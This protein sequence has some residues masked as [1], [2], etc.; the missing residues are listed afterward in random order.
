MDEIQEV[1]N[2]MTE[3]KDGKPDM[4]LPKEASQKYSRTYQRRL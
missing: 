3:V 1:V 2:E 4:A